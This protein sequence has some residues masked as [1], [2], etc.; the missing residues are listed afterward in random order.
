MIKINFFRTL[1]INWRFKV[2]PSRNWDRTSLEV[3]QN[4][5]P[6][7]TATIW[8]VWKFSEEFYFQGLSL[9][10]LIPTWCCRN[11]LIPRWFVE[12]NQWQLFNIC[13]R[14]YLQIMYPIKDL[15]SRPFKK[16]NND[17]LNFKMNK[18]FKWMFLQRYL[19]G[20]KHMK[21]CLISLNVREFKSKSQ[22]DTPSHSLECLE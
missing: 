5:Y 6:Q 18:K 21:R 9:L 17:K 14:K 8:S 12:N 11:S 4:Y 16:L 13:L 1:K 3:P 20:Q 22:E 2:F 10:D 15:Y 7:R 19:K